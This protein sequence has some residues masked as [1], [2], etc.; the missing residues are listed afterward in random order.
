MGAV[1]LARQMWF[2]SQRRL[3]DHSR[4]DRARSGLHRPL[5]PGGLHTAQLQHHNAVQIYDL[6]AEGKTHFFSMEFVDGETLAQM[7]KRQGRLEPV[8]AA[9]YVLQAARAA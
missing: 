5:H 4:Q 1:Y 2:R 9:G 3:E 6:G 8:V 7:V